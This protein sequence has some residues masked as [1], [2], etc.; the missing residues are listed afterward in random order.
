MLIDVP[1][2]GFINFNN[3]FSIRISRYESGA[4]KVV[5]YR[6]DGGHTILYSGDQ[7]QCIKEIMRIHD[8]Y[9]NGDSHVVVGKEDTDEEG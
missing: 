3:V 1:S 9:I 6:P 2:F 7:D 5:A 4:G 8:A